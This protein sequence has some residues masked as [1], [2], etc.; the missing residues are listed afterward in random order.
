MFTLVGKWPA[1]DSLVGIVLQPVARP[2]YL[3][4]PSEGF[5]LHILQQTVHV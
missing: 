3:L 1:L 2:N 5:P 4:K